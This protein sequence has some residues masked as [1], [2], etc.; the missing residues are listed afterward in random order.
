MKDV[1]RFRAATVAIDAGRNCGS[2]VSEAASSAK[3]LPAGARESDYLAHSTRIT[4]LP[5]TRRAAHFGFLSV[6]T[7]K[8]L[9]HGLRVGTGMELLP[10]VVIA[11]ALRHV[12]Q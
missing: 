8:Q 9:T 7:G 1:R 5:G 4:G 2:A 10:E 11:E 6:V 3:S 12:G